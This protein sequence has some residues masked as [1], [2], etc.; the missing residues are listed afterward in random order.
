MIQGTNSKIQRMMID[1]LSQ[2]ERT[3]TFKLL[4]KGR[5][6]QKSWIQNRYFK[7]EGKENNK[8]SFKWHSQAKGTKR[9]KSFH[10]KF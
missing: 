9:N 8:L 1:Y 6:L 3:I 2:N 7:I 4:E 10:S 5:K